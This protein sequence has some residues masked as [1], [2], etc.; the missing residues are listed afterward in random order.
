MKFIII[1]L[2]LAVAAGCS[3]VRGKSS[4]TYKSKKKIE[5]NS[6]AVEESLIIKTGISEK[7]EKFNT[8]RR[9]EDKYKSG[10]SVI[11]DN[12]SEGKKS[13]ITEKD[14]ISKKTIQKPSQ[15]KK[16]QTGT[17]KSKKLTI[18]KKS[19]FSD[20][21]I[22][23]VIPVVASNHDDLGTE[24]RALVN[25]FNS[26]D[27]KSACN[28]FGIISET[29]EKGD[30][31]W[32]ETQFYLCE[33]QIINEEFFDAEKNLKR[34]LNDYDS[35]QIVIEKTLVRLGQLYCYLD[36]KDDAQRIFR[37][38]KKDFPESKY[39]V[40]ANCDVVQH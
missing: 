14:F 17:D 22:I 16:K 19:R 39:L 12:T 8:I 5:A 35:P 10:N 20:T 23:N 21:T 25:D 30:S 36:K 2:I 28:K 7:S 40:L 37:R 4:G 1:L 15:P 32:Y 33:C 6:T 29:L 24:F 11:P 13:N 18:E 38:L 34:L 3:N 27:E 31:L 9:S 26:S